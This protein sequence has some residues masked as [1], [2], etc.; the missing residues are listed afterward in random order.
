M[1]AL[2]P[3]ILAAAHIGLTA[4]GGLAAKT[5]PHFAIAPVCRTDLASR[6][7]CRRDQCEARA[8]L[9]R[10]WQQFSRDLRASCTRQ[11][12]IGGAP[13]YVELLDCLQIAEAA[14]VLP[15]SDTLTGGV[16]R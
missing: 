7:A 1:T 15:Q 13:G 10:Q 5:V 16:S 12:R 14:G 9:Q 2:L 3:T 11:A 6:A 4:H 8:H